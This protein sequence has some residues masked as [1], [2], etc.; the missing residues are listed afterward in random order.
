MNFLQQLDEAA[1][2]PLDQ[3]KDKMKKDPRVKQVFQRSLNVDEIKDP[4]T[5][6]R[7][8]RYYLFSNPHVRAHIE[9]RGDA[10][11]V[12]R[13]WWKNVTNNLRPGTPIKQTD[14]DYLMDL[15][16]F[17]FKDF[18]QLQKNDLSSR[19]VETFHEW[20]R[21]GLNQ[22]ASY[23]A[24][25]FNSLNLRPDVPVR[26]YRG[27]MFD[28]RSFRNEGGFLS[29]GQGLKFLRS[30]RE[31]TRVANLEFENH[32][33]WTTDKEQALRVALFGANN[34]WEKV[35]DSTPRQIRKHSGVLS[36]VVST[37]AK[38]SDIMVDLS[39]TQEALGWPSTGPDVNVMVL[40][41]GTY[42][43]R[44]VHKFTPDGEEDPSVAKKEDDADLDSI[45]SQLSLLGRVLKL[46]WPQIE[47]RGT[48]IGAAS[49][50]VGQVGVLV[51]PETGSLAVR[52]MKQV[53]SFYRKHLQDV[54][55]K[56]LASQ[57]GDNSKVYQALV[58]IHELFNGYIYHAKAADP[59]S[60]N[61]ASRLAG[62]IRFK[63]V[64]NADD[65]LT[66]RPDHN[67]TRLRDAVAH[68]VG[69]KRW[70]NSTIT[71]VFSGFA[72]LGDPNY[73]VPDKIHL[74]GWAQQKVLVDKAMD[75]FY[76]TIGKPKPSSYTEQ[77][78]DFASVLDRANVV[79]QSVRFLQELKAAAQSVDE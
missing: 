37:L 65:L 12:S 43:C 55:P 17:L 38:P 60:S 54:D 41:P 50:I 16:K 63:D 31:G 35:D 79:A 18:N 73:K 71:S 69:Q 42:T 10:R 44:L 22:L 14:I 70:T 66:A 77:A 61:R 21:R 75:G 39:R 26:L 33:I 2:I 34:S 4:D 64:E 72:R 46:P 25:E 3:L 57:A 59:S 76:A 51:D 56:K 30:I 29:N 23:T 8:L 5:F 49:K 67:N 28:E 74:A 9:R 15:V 19:A 62:T 7:T 40:N 6:I 53:I 52:L 78:K 27:F 24:R 20:Y 58:K 1:N 47:F 45:K 36:F 32:T 13:H 48:D 68:I 11:D